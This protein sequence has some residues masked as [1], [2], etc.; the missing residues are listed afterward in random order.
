LSRFS[1]MHGRVTSP[2][3]NDDS[4]EVQRLV[5]AY[6]LGHHGDANA[7]HRSAV[8]DEY[9]HRFGVAG[10]VEHCVSRLR[11]IEE[12]GI[13]RVVVLDLGSPNDEQLI[14]SRATLLSEVMPALQATR[15][16]PAGAPRV[17]A[18]T[19]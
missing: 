8:S 6:D 15:P 18:A 10:P 11:E 3:R 1:A 4:A 14:Y 13:D 12:I 2:M 9:I 17:G 7:D 16:G 19:R 5:S